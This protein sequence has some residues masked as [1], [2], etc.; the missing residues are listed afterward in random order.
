MGFCPSPFRK[1]LYQGPIYRKERNNL[2]RQDVLA[3]CNTMCQHMLL[4]IKFRD[5]VVKIIAVGHIGSYY[6]ITIVKPSENQKGHYFLEA[7]VACLS[8]NHLV[9]PL[10]NLN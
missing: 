2:Y 4:L 7:L 9:W 6:Y 3:T 5:W 1:L 8:Q 10:L